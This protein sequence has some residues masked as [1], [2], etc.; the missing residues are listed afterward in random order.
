MLFADFEEFG[1]LKTFAALE[2]TLGEVYSCFFVIFTSFPFLDI[3][4]GSASNDEALH[5]YSGAQ[6]ERQGELSAWAVHM[7]GKDSCAA[8]VDMAT[9]SLMP[10][11]RAENDSAPALRTDLGIHCWKNAGLVKG[12]RP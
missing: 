6:G 11:T 9:G 5:D 12:I 3:E 10:H 2:S 7:N 4:V 8:G 1:L